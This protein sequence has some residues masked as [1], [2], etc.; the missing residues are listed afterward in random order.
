MVALALVTACTTDSMADTTPV[1][2]RIRLENVG[3]PQ[4]ASCGSYDPLVAPGIYALA[5]DGSPLFD[6]GALAPAGLE[7]LAEDG[8]PT[9]LRD[10]LL[11][12]T[13]L[14]VV[15]VFDTPDG[16][17]ESGV[18]APGAAF[19]FVVLATPGMQLHLAGMFVESNDWFV[20]THPEGLELFDGDTPRLGDHTAALD[21]YDAGTEVNEEPGCGPNQA[22]RQAGPNTGPTEAE[23][24]TRAAD[25]QDGFSVPSAADIL[26]L[27]VS[28]PSDMP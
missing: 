13:G 14:D 22:P 10:A 21:L 5:T 20:A 11:G 6:V 24:V 19:S 3:A 28:L 15:D 1:Q 9:V 2:L 25:R 8:D 17:Y 4:D 23:P 18:I 7:S 27:E 12:T 26:R 16:T